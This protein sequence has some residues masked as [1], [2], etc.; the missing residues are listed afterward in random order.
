VSLDP[1]VSESPG[2]VG[3]LSE[4]SISEFSGFGGDL[5]LLLGVGS[6]RKNGSSDRNLS[7]HFVY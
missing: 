4:E 6:S 2:L 3:L 1:L 5:K 7:K